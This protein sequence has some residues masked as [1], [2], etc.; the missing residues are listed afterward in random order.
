MIA[1]L[2]SGVSHEQIDNLI[3]WFKEQGLKVHI[4]EGDY[5]SVV[6]GTLHNKI[7]KSLVHFTC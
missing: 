7:Q 1:V 4:S 3:E 5:T 2:K 6:L